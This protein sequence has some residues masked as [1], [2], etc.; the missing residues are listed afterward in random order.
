MIRL[1]Y[2]LLA[3]SIIV[4]DGEKEG[5]R[6]N[7][8]Y[9]QQQFDLA[10]GAYEAG[11]SSLSEGAPR[12]LR[13]GLLNNLGAALLKSGDVEAA[14]EAFATALRS[15]SGTA[16]VART[17][18]NAGNAS[19]SSDNLEEALD[20]YRRSLLS[21]ADNEDAKYN[22]ELVKRQLEQQQEQQQGGGQNDEQ[23]QEESDQENDEGEQNQEGDNQDEGEQNQEQEEQQQQGSENEQQEDG[24][25]DGQEAEPEQ[26]DESGSSDAPQPSV[27]D[28]SEEQ[29]ERIL[30]ALQN[31]EE[32]LLRQVQRPKSRPRQ[33]EKDW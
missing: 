14:E 28:L 23:E 32:Q 16:D 20:H 1:L 11:L 7:E 30:Q 31:E 4:N 6:G 13:Y 24:G 10:V 18:Y 21:D 8:L 12:L 27:T 25:Q 33:V 5:R 15:A 29:A 3:F 22:Y 9:A 17:E 26:P 2:I 19:Y